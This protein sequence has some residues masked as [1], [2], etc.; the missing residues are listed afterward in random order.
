[1]KRADKLKWSRLIVTRDL[2]LLQEDRLVKI[3]NALGDGPLVRWD[4]ERGGWGLF[5]EKKYE[6]GEKV[7]EYGGTISTYEVAGPY[8]AL[9]GDI[10]VDGFCGF[11]LGIQRGRWINEYDR[12][13]SH[14]NTELGRIV[15]T[16]RTVEKGEQFFA[17]YG[18]E[19]ERHY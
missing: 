2:I 7:T 8:V 14:V 9:M 16:T 3:I 13:R 5:A 12:E 17:D 11:R 4:P 6:E 15:R 1:M 19:Y 10:H 18:N